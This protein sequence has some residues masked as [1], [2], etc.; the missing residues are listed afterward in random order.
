[1]DT[2]TFR[3][4]RYAEDL[5]TK[6]NLLESLEKTS[7]ASFFFGLKKIKQSPERPIKLKV[8][9]NNHENLPTN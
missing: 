8:I 7:A 9:N 1:M 4:E 2:D 6:T 5:I 3:L